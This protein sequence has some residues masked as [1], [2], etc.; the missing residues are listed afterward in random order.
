MIEAMKVTLPRL[1]TDGYYPD[2]A[3][4]IQQAAV[5][6][7]SF[8]AGDD[9]NPPLPHEMRPMGQGIW[10]LRTPDLRFDGWFPRR[11]YFVIGAFDSKTGTKAIGRNTQM[12]AEVLEL[13]ENT[14]LEG[15]VFLAAESFHELI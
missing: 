13:R 3:S 1:Q 15:G 7:N 6:F 12:V 2:S 4:P 14:N 11:N 8:V 10:R 5:L 9:L